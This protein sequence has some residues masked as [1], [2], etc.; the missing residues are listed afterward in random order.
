[1]GGLGRSD[2]ASTRIN[3]FQSVPERSEKAA[4][5]DASS[6]AAGFQ[7]FSTLSPPDVLL[8]RAPSQQRQ[9]RE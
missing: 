5:P 1:M 4:A 6:R 3:P 8:V 7:R 2:G 9:L